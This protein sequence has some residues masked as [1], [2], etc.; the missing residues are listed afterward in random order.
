MKC[1]L[2]DSDF[3][4]IEFRLSRTNTVHA[5]RCLQCAGWWFPRALPEYLDAAAI[6]QYESP[7]PSY[8]LKAFDL[9]CPSDQ[10]LL[11]QSDSDIAPNGAKSWHCPECAG[12]FF[13][14]GQLALLAEW[15]GARTPA[16][17][18]EVGFGRVKVAGALSLTT[19]LGIAVLSSINRTG[20]TL[21]A[22]ETS[23]LPTSG[24]NIFTLILLSLTYIA[25]T[26]LAV[27]SR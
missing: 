5:K 18:H 8:S 11:T 21:S 10:T 24:P 14:K 13:P 3:E 19:V 1:P 12:E 27:L 2:C 6:R 25:G 9:L 15:K 17:K 22:A 23:V 4:P 20:L 26:I 16:E 7:Q